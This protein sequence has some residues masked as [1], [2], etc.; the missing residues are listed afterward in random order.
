MQITTT[1]RFYIILFRIAIINYK[2]WWGCEKKECK[3]IHSLQTAVLKFLKKLKIQLPL[4]LPI[5]SIF[6]KEFKPGYDGAICT[7]TFIAALFT[8]AKLWK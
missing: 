4:Q 2:C 1:L 6:W 5:L 3:L 7:P 8:K